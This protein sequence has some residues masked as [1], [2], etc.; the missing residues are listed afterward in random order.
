MRVIIL[1]KIQKMDL[2]TGRIEF[3]NIHLYT[4]LKYSLT[5]EMMY[6]S[7]FILERLPIIRIQFLC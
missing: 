1:I 5:K 6:N 4:P 7:I 3:S 2:E